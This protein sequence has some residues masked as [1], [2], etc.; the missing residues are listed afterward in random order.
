MIG[1]FEMFDSG[2]ASESDWP[3][4]EI[5]DPGTMGSEIPQLNSTR[6]I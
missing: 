5:P 1:L 2:D 4:R 3:L 6:S